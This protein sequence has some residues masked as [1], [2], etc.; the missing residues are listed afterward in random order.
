MAFNQFTDW[1][2]ATYNGANDKEQTMQ[3]QALLKQNGQ[4]VNT[5]DGTWKDSD[6]AALKNAGANAF[7]P[8]N[9]QKT[10]FGWVNSGNTVPW[11]SSEADRVKQN[12]AHLANDGI[13][14]NTVTD[15]LGRQYQTWQHDPS[16]GAFGKSDS[17]G[18]VFNKAGMSSNPYYLNATIGVSRDR[19][20]TEAPEI[21]GLSD[22]MLQR[23]YEAG[24][25]GTNQAL[26]FDDYYVTPGGQVGTLAGTEG[27]VR[28]G[29]IREALARLTGQQT[30]M[31]GGFNAG[32]SAQFVKPDFYNPYADNST[33][34]NYGERQKAEVIDPFIQR[35]HQIAAQGGGEV[36]T[37]TTSAP[38]ANGN[39]V[40]TILRK[41]RELEEN[42]RRYKEGY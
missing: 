22:L 37:P 28:I 31:G 1:K 3:L 7:Q 33:P 30:K 15:N 38:T 12:A 24:T 4:N 25:T 10:N 8:T 21:A 32:L 17:T 42:E 35:L 13:A 29:D 39:I 2:N 20:N 41:N 9:E 26:N 16:N 18:G 5:V 14:F 27:A 23:A 40:Q 34:A 6:N 19:I 36:S 11:Y